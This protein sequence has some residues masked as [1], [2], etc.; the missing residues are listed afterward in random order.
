MGRAIEAAPWASPR[1]G[2]KG[3]TAPLTGG[4]KGLPM[5]RPM[6]RHMYRPIGRP[7]AKSMGLYT[8]TFGGQDLH[9]KPNHN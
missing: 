2:I 1:R 9:K 4:P 7:M 6:G 8:P 5:G 3:D